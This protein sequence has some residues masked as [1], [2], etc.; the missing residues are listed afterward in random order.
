MQVPALQALSQHT[1][2]TQKPVVQSAAAE[3][4]WPVVS[5]HWPALLQVWVPVHSGASFLP[6]TVVHTPGLALHV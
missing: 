4:G 1:P 6:T 5:L 2:S 3:Q